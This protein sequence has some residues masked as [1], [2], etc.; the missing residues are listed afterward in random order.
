MVLPLLYKHRIRIQELKLILDEFPVHRNMRVLEV[1]C[2]SGV[3]SFILAQK[4]DFVV[5]SDI[6]LSQVKLRLP[7]LIKCSGEFLPLKKP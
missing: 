4:A 5:S 1:G 3:Q 7:H 2:G 6:D